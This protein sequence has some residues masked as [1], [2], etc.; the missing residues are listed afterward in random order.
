M[1]PAIILFISVIILFI[2]V[3]MFVFLAMSSHFELK[4]QVLTTFSGYT[5]HR[6]L[7][8]KARVIR[9]GNLSTSSSW[10]QP[11][12][13]E[14][15]SLQWIHRIEQKY[16]KFKCKY[17]LVVRIYFLTARGAVDSKN[18]Q[19]WYRLDCHAVPYSSTVR[20]SKV[21]KL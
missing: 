11:H 9:D 19:F 2:S 8:I 1:Q 16:A 13:W 14:I 7:T 3:A 12:V 18:C 21:G 15:Q 10:R 20:Y 6:R 17:L 4:E 5:T